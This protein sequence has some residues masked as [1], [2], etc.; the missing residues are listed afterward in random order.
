MARTRKPSGSKRSKSRRRGRNAT[1]LVR[2][3][4]TKRGRKSLLIVCEGTKTEP[5]YFQSLRKKLK[6]GSVQVEVK[7]S[8]H[9]TAPIKIVKQAIRLRKE[10]KKDARQSSS[11][12]E[13]DEIWCVIDRENLQQNQTFHNAI[14]KAKNEK[15]EL[16]ISIPCFEIWYLLHF[17][18]STRAF[19][20]GR[21]IKNA[22]KKY[23]P[24]YSESSDVF[25]TLYP[26]TRQAIC[27]AT[28]LLDNHPG[29]SQHPNPSTSV[30]IL[31]Q[32]LLDMAS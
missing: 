3:P 17:E 31:V 26:K 22:L 15:L 13:Y 12:A 32:K 28:Q 7:S 29:G 18:K 20:D 21:E 19:R 9:D 2:H 10:R 8:N 23:I 1:N 4:G 11:L 6:L 14:E 5:N 25:E 16:G 30:H 27:H 24:E